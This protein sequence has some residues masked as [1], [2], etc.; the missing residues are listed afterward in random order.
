MLHISL[1]PDTEGVLRERAKA[2]GE[3]ISAYAAR[4]LQEA[5]ATPTL[6]TI[7]VLE[8]AQKTD[9]SICKSH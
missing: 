7:T 1:P 3:D 8:L 4:L 5:L 6:G 2:N 9:Y